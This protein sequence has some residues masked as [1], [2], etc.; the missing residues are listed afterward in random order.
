MKKVISILL[1]LTMAI[2]LAAIPV[3]AAETEKAVTKTFVYNDEILRDVITVDLTVT[4]KGSYSK[5]GGDAYITSLSG[6][7]TGPLA[8]RLTFGYSKSGNEGTLHIYDLGTHIYDYNYH[9]NTSGGI[10]L[11]SKD[12]LV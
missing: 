11:V 5:V 6:S 2:G 4:V 3:F 8:F 9:I 1:V 12:R 10:T 7:A